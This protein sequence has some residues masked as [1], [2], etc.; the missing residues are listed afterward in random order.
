MSTT[1]SIMEIYDRGTVV[2]IKGSRGLWQ[3]LIEHRP[4]GAQVGWLGE[5]LRP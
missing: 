2:A 3:A 5:R 4:L 1:L